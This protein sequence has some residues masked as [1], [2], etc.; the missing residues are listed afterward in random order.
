MTTSFVLEVS[1]IGSIPE[2]PIEEAPKV[3]QEITVVIEEEEEEE[4]EIIVAKPKKVKIDLP[5]PKP[6]DYKLNMD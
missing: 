4:E 3:V 1:I 2:E 6:L 5:P